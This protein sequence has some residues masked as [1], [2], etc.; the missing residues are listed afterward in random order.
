MDIRITVN[1]LRGLRTRDEQSRKDNGQFGEGSGGS[2]SSPHHEVK[3]IDHPSRPHHTVAGEQKKSSAA[4]VHRNGE[5]VGSVE[6]YVDVKHGARLGGNAVASKK[7]VVRHQWKLNKGH[8]KVGGEG[9]QYGTGYTS[10]AA[11][12]EALQRA[13]QR[14][15]GD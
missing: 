10:Q 8:F 13:R 2:N 11:A 1:G 7:E 12:I 9:T 14:Q 3:K 5:H 4:T 6:S 15:M